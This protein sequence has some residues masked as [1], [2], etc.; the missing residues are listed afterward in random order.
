MT[1]KGIITQ[2]DL[3]GSS[4]NFKFNANKAIEYSFEYN[5]QTYSAMLESK[6]FGRQINYMF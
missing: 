1:A 3:E 4:K 6:K 5:G 2:E